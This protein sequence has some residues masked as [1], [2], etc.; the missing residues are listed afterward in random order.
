MATLTPVLLIS[1]YSDIK[2][3]RDAIK[4]CDVLTP[5]DVIALKGKVSTDSEV[6]LIDTKGAT[7]QIVIIAALFLRN[8]GKTVIVGDIDLVPSELLEEIHS[9]TIKKKSSGIS[10]LTEV[11]LMEDAMKIY[12]DISDVVLIFEEEYL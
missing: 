8:A 10:V 7:K 5:N 9:F 12:G 2:Y 6:A 4:V 11:L 3:Q 1:T